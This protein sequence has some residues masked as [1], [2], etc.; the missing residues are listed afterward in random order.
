MVI[1]M[2]AMLCLASLELSIADGHQDIRLGVDVERYRCCGCRKMQICCGC[3]KI[4]CVASQELGIAGCHQDRIWCGYSKIQIQMLCGC[5]QIQ[6]LWM[7]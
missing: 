1:K 5:I 6:M 2:L 3:S 4:V 7:L